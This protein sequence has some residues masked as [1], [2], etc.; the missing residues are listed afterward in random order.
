MTEHEVD[1]LLVTWTFSLRPDAVLAMW[2]RFVTL[3]IVS[4]KCMFGTIKIVTLLL[5][6]TLIRLFLHV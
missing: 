1:M 2:S 4:P 6:L 3:R 5:S